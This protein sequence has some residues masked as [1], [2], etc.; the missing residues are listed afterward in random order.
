MKCRGN[1]VNGAGRCGGHQ[2]H[3]R[4]D[5]CRQDCRDEKQLFHL[6][7]SH[8]TT[9]RGAAYSTE[10]LEYVSVGPIVE[11]ALAWNAFCTPLPI[12]ITYLLNDVAADVEQEVRRPIAA[13]KDG[14][15]PA[16][17]QAHGHV[18]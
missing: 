4:Q 17:A 8:V 2:E 7:A 11:V 3:Q 15:R 16:R 18:V 10:R 13:D 6:D 12:D 5:G 9:S 14:N 1:G